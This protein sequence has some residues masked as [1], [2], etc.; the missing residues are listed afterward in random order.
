[1]N[2]LQSLENA[3]S[4]SLQLTPRPC[5]AAAASAHH[6]CKR[7]CKPALRIYFAV[8]R[9]AGHHPTVC[10]VRAFTESRHAGCPQA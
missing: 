1:M 3:S 2:A 5:L 7:P 9:G 4:R 8:D 10:G 6:K